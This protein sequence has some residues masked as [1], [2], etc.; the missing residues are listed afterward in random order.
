MNQQTVLKNV[1]NNYAKAVAVGAYDSKL[2]GRGSKCDNVRQYWED[3]YTRYVLSPPIRRL[4][5]R[6]RAENRGVRIMDLGCGAGEGWN[7]LTTLPQTSP[8]L[9]AQFNSLLN[10]SDIEFYQGVDISPEMIDKAISIHAHHDQTQF[11]VADLDRGLPVDS[12]EAPY[13]V[14]FSSYGALSHLSDDSLSK[15]VGDICQHMGD[16]AIFVADLLGRYSYEWPC[17][18]GEISGKSITQ[19]TYSMSYLYPPEMR[20]TEDVERFPIRY[21]GGEEIDRFLRMITESM[22]VKVGEFQLCDRS[23]LVGRHTDTREFNPQISPLRSA[24]NSLHAID[25][26]TDLTRLIFE[27]QPHPQ[28]PHI[29]RFFQNLESAWNSVVYGCMESLDMWRNPEKLLAEPP[30]EY[31]PIV[32]DSVRILRQLVNQAPNLHF[33]D[34]RANLIEPQLAYLLRNL[35]WNFQQ[36]L[37]ASHGLLAIYEF[38]R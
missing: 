20:N 15:L 19:Q 28:H 25:T 34:P 8:T 27:Y 7:I 36:G 31:P 16:R 23:I 4:I 38:R 12:G 18:W 17:Y 30:I 5:E 1:L 32:L 9:D 29:N 6:K 26:R 21:W 11:I 14:Y 2:A 37:G 3:R 33:D 13:D 10:E 24:I 22:N 35:E